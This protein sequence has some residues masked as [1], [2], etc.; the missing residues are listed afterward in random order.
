MT[1][2]TES[3]ADLR[4]SS[5][6]AIERPIPGLPLLILGILSLPVFGI[7]VLVLFG[8]R[9][10]NPNQSAVIVVFGRY[11]GTIRRPG[12]WWVNPFA[13]RL[14]MSLRVHNFDSQKLKVND[15]RG[16]P[17]EI[18]AVVV[19]RVRDTAQAAF[20]VEDHESYV[21]VQSEAAIRTTA[22]KHPYDIAEEG[23]TSLRGDSDEVNGELALQLRDR[24]AL[25]GVQV[26]EVRISHLAYAPEIAGAMLRRQ[27]AEAIIDART[28]IVEGAVGM[29][30]MALEH[31]RERDV[32]QL[33]EERKAAMVSN[34]LVVLCSES[35]TTPVVNAGAPVS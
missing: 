3:A 15:L 19:W 21:R 2:R 13:S 26:M 29:V 25:A 8:L 9:L 7:G 32:V 14:R 24:L 6:Q 16:N 12:L 28:R 20:D 23:Q 27:Q 22:S 17:I 30:Q 10:V 4:R 11:K 33:D 1:L 5:E 31:L 34:L 18:A 35:A